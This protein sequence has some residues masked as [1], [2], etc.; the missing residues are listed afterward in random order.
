MK[1][2]K[3]DKCS[4]EI[5]YALVRTIRIGGRNIT[6]INELH[7]GRED[8]LDVFESQLECDDIKIKNGLYCSVVTPDKSR[9]DAEFVHVFMPDGDE[10]RKEYIFGNFIVAGHIIKDSKLEN[11]KPN[12]DKKWIDDRL[13]L[14]V[15]IDKNVN[16]D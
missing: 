9:D 6:K 2:F 13:L 14:A 4:P 12:I 7:I 16:S 5:R 1:L 3:N 10:S 8:A 15:H 11:L